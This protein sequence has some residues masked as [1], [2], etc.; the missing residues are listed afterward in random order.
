[1][2]I[3]PESDRV[4]GVGIVGANAGELIFEAVLALEMDA[5]AEDIALTALPHP[6]L[7]ETLMECA[8]C[9]W[10]RNA[11][12]FEEKTNTVNRRLPG[13]SASGCLAWPHGKNGFW[14]W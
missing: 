7:S 8:E 2:L 5:N 4:L 11:P 14:Q 1:M 9:F 10:P 12:N 6:T 3:D 13:R